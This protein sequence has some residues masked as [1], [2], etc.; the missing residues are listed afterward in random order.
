[1]SQQNSTTGDTPDLATD[2]KLVRA[3]TGRPQADVHPRYYGAAERVFDALEGRLSNDTERTSVSRDQVTKAM[4]AY[5]TGKR[6]E[7]GSIQHRSGFEQALRSMG[8]KIEGDDL[9]S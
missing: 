5:W 1:M 6:H 3:L 8:L 9:N 7:D 2:L 4:Q